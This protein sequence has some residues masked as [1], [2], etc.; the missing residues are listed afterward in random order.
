M[1]PTGRNAKDRV[2]LGLTLQN[3]GMALMFVYLRRK[4]GVHTRMFGAGR[5]GE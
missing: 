5:A 4:D 3:I 1:T 2:D